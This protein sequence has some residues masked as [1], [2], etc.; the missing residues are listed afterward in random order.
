MKLN[1]EASDTLIYT[2]FYRRG[3]ND[4]SYILL[5]NSFIWY[6]KDTTVFNC[7]KT[8]KNSSCTSNRNNIYYITV[9][10]VTEFHNCNLKRPNL[11]DH[12]SSKTV[13]IVR[14]SFPVLLCGLIPKLF[15]FFN[16]RSPFQRPIFKA[17]N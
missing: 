12:V 10:K 11:R 1:T 4:S 17:E 2:Y 8:E 16:E 13:S 6:L 3:S 5:H 15:N 14:F 7:D 9:D